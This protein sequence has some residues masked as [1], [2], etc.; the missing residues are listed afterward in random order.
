MCILK[1]EYHKLFLYNPSSKLKWFNNNPICSINK[2]NFDFI[3]KALAHVIAHHLFENINNYRVGNFFVR[4]RQIVN[5]NYGKSE[6]LV[7]DELRNGHYLFKRFVP[8]HTKFNNK[9]NTQPVSFSLKRKIR[10]QTNYDFLKKLIFILNFYYRRM[11]KKTRLAHSAAL[12]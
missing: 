7:S 8:L 10:T 6:I 11:K 9:F 3:K 12:A 5:K 1:I 2:I 4:R